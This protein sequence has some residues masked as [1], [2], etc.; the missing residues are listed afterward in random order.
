MSSQ[1]QIQASRA[2]GARS[3]GPV[4]PQGKQTSSRNNTRHGLLS[5]TVVLEGESEKRF[6][7]L[8]EAFMAD[9]QPRSATEL[10]LVETMVVARWR[11]LR[12][13]GLQKTALE[14]RMALRPCA[15]CLPSVLR[16]TI[17]ASRIFS[18]AT[19]SHLIVSS[20][21]PLKRFFFS[22]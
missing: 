14:R 13:W 19:K 9:H 12:T 8:L 21:E 2:N 10:A 11:L 4:T 22:K 18:S 20:P 1:K 17:L 16:P 7:E 5:G 6:I 15:P 3:R